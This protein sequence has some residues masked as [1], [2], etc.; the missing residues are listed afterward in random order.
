MNNVSESDISQVLE[1]KPS[2]LFHCFLL[3]TLPKK[4][5]KTILNPFLAFSLIDFVHFFI[6]W[7][8]AILNAL[9]AIAL[10]LN[11]CFSNTVDVSKWQER[12]ASQAGTSYYFT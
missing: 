10:M 7:C 12:P 2:T 9:G 11:L 4:Y 5:I 1:Q 6:T 3:F 8:V